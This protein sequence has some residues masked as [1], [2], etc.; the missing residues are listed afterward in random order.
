MI[1]V[2]NSKL[3]IFLFLAIQVLFC[4][5][6]YKDA[7]PQSYGDWG[8]SKPTV[9]SKYLGKDYVEFQP[10]NKPD[11]EN[12]IMNYIIAIDSNNKGKITILR[13]K[14]IPEKDFL[15]VNNKLYSVLENYDLISASAVNDIIKRLT[16]TYGTATIQK[17]KNMTIY[18]YMSKK[19]KV[20]VLTYSKAGKQECKVYYYASQLFKMLIS[21]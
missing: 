2:S 19:T 17:D 21:E 9:I 16:D 20:L 5:M 7:L 6:F 14:K 18:S 15:L 3:P 12:K 8:I 10:I 4:L 11:Y 1:K 13:T